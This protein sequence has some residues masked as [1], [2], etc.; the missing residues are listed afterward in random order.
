MQGFNDAPLIC[1]MV[2]ENANVPMPSDQPSLKI[3]TVAYAGQSSL[4]LPSHVPSRIHLICDIHVDASFSSLPRRFC[5][6]S[7]PSFRALRSSGV[8][9][10]DSY[11]R[12]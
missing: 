4:N 6:M 2:L 5:I 9:T 11:G 3:V 1:T 10:H 8:C 12:F 7:T